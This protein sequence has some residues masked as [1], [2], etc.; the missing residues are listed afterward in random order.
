MFG[1]MC[2]PFLLNATIRA[3]VQK[4][5]VENTKKLLLQFLQD[6][7]VGNTATSFNDLTKTT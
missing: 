1:L 3:H 6:L 5:L 4:D 7:Y 2:S